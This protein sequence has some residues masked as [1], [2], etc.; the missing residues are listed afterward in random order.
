MGACR[1]KS[2]PGN[3]LD[4]LRDGQL[5]Q[6]GSV[7]TAARPDCAEGLREVKRRRTLGSRG[8]A[9]LEAPAMTA[10]TSGPIDHR[11]GP[12]V[13]H[14]RSTTAPFLDPIDGERVVDLIV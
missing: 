13:Q 12:E 4:S 10:S 3:P 8:W 6:N 14:Q 1:T 5:H 7:L 2:H 11:S 9:A